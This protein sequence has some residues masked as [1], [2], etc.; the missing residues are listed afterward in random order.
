MREPQNGG[1]QS[2]RGKTK[3]HNKTPNL[4]ILLVYNFLNAYLK[5]ISQL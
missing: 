2:R 1:C 3:H 4:K 5:R